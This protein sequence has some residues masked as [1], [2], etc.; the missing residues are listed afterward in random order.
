MGLQVKIG[1]GSHAPQLA[2]AEGEEVF[3]VGGGVGIVGEF[4]LFVVTIAQVFLFQTQALQELLAFALPV[5]KPL[6]LG[7][8]FA[9]E[10]QLHLLKFRVRKTKLPGV[11]SLRKALPTWPMP[12][13]SFFRWCA[14]HF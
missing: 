2:P 13:G 3:D 4:F 8:G 6:K 14:A 9:E 10:L 7:A 5:V 11:I 1:A 12:K